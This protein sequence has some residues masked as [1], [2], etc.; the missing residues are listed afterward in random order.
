MKK[1][2]KIICCIII[3]F[4][5]II[6]YVSYITEHNNQELEHLTKKIAKKYSKKENIVSSNEYGNFYIIK[7][8]SKVIVLTKDYKEVVKEDLSKLKKELSDLPLIY[9]TNKIMYEKTIRKNN[10]VKY[11]YYDAITGKKIKSTILERQ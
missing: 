4:I 2:L 5:I 1:I 7:T 6:L 9:K 3:A 11:E 8:T 10:K